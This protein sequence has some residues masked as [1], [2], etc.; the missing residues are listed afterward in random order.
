MAAQS[1]DRLDRAVE[2]S[3]R[4]RTTGLVF[5]LEPSSPGGP[6]AYFK[7]FLDVTGASCFLVLSA[8]IFAA[9]AILI[10]VDSRGPVMVRQERVGRDLR[11]FKM[12]K[13]RSMV[14][15]ADQ[16]RDSLQHLNEANGP[17]FKI[18]DDPRT[19]AIG[20]LLRRFSLDELPQLV[21]VIRGEMSLV[22]PRP[23]FQSEVDEDHLRQR[24]RLRFTPGMTGLWQV[25]G[26][27]ELPYESMLELDFAYMRRWTLYADLKILLMTVPAVIRGRGAC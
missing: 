7:R 12:L 10:R 25:S 26:R 23:P 19:T 2:G 9:I 6:E 1:A 27:S 8:P 22:G 13:F 18:R 15:G 5:R 3:P 11:S 17:L 16:L 20:K 14:L 21:N 4:W 24:L